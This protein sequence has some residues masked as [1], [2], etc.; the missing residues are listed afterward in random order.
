MCGEGTY[1][2]GISRGALYFLFFMRVNQYQNHQST[3]SEAF[4]CSLA[5]TSCIVSYRGDEGGI[6]WDRLNGTLATM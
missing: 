1:N 6:G 5:I 4:W 2:L 3:S